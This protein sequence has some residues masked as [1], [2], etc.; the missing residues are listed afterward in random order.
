MERSELTEILEAKVREALE[1]SAKRKKPSQKPGVG[2]TLVAMDCSRRAA[3]ELFDDIARSERYWMT[4]PE[5]RA[6]FE[7]WR[8][9]FDGKMQR[10]LRDGF[11]IEEN[12]VADLRAAGFC[13]DTH[14]QGMQYGFASTSPKSKRTY[15]GKLDGIVRV[16]PEWFP[17][18]V[19]AVL[20]I[21]SMNSKKWNEW[22]RH[23]ILR[24]NPSYA[25][26]IW[27]YQGMMRLHNP[28]LLIGYNKDTSEYGCE[29]VPFDEE[30]FRNLIERAGALVEAADPEDL[31]RAGVSR[32]DMMCRWCPWVE[33]CWGATEPAGD[34]TVFA[35]EWMKT[36]E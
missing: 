35:P 36:D 7:W 17:M 10:V 30:Q 3:Y 9:N 29:L 34:W 14:H 5:K 18:Q 27:Q 2:A 6:S 21:K 8:A 11:T 4:P 16:A 15:S 33:K 25:R 26:Q 19:P 13:I 32:D 23:G 31:P 24:S 12:A 22:Q 28:A 1:V 20:E